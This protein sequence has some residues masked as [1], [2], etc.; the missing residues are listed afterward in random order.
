M[1]QTHVMVAA[2]LCWDGPDRERP[3]GSD[4]TFREGLV[5]AAAGRLDQAAACWA[6]TLA[7]EPSH[8]QARFNRLLALTRLERL[9]EAADEAL[10]GEHHHPDNPDFP[11]RRGQILAR[12]GRLDEAVTSLHRSLTLADQPALWWVLG[13]IERDRCR[14][15]AASEALGHVDSET[16]A[17]FE[18]AQL[19]L[20]QG[21]WRQG[22]A[23]WESRLRRPQA[24]ED[25]WTI[26]EW[27]GGDLP[28]LDLLVYGEQG[29]GDTLQMLRYVPELTARGATVRLAVHDSLLRLL[30]GFPGVAQVLPLSHP[31]CPA[32]HRVSIMSLPHRL[33]A[34]DPW[35]ER[36]PYLHTRPALLAEAGLKVGVV[37][38]GSA[39]FANAAQRHI[40]R[41]M[42]EPLRQIPGARLYS[43][44]L[45]QS[46]DDPAIIDLA[47]RIADWADTAALV[48]G[49]DLLISVDTGTAH[50]A[51]A[52]GR[53]L[54]LL[55]HQGCDWR[56]GLGDT[57]PWYPQARLYR[58]HAAGD[59]NGVMGRVAA[60]LR[61]LAGVA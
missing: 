24:H 5:H 54:W 1:Y 28:D 27:T 15:E 52:L 18:L 21:R 26:P 43:L 45:D 30:T 16:E 14:W 32:T 12:L 9:D 25:R 33:P 50:L 29:V 20:R 55:L 44:Q 40:G 46:P 48:A 38:A 10:A 41:S 51:G 11:G 47:P 49:L 3:V 58:Q 57:T 7:T 42:L 60:D 35:P 22:W 53:P 34:D 56:W 8:A 37:W 36:V 61:A 59:W 13:L 19:A 2:G 23:L 17:R 6:E 31:D 4:E 39:A